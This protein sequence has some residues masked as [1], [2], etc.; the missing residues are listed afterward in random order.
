MRYRAPQRTAVLIKLLGKHLLQVKI[1]TLDFHWRT[2]FVVY[3]HLEISEYK[4][5]AS[6]TKWLGWRKMRQLERNR[7]VVKRQQKHLAHRRLKASTKDGGS[8]TSVCA[9]GQNCRAKIA[10]PKFQSQNFKAQYFG[11]QGWIFCQC[12]SLFS[13]SRPPH[14]PWYRLTWVLGL[15]WA[16][17]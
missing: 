7:G 9:G 4:T 14:L 15:I 5:G 3:I 2:I 12:W 1:A 10:E 8:V 16:S 13:C 6:F 11:A 17:G